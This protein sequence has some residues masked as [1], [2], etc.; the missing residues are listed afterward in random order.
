MDPMHSGMRYTPKATDHDWDTSVQFLPVSD[1]KKLEKKKGPGKVGAA[2]GLVVFF[3]VI[4]LMTGLLVWHF[5]FRKDVRVKKMYTG[6]MRITNQAFQEAY[7]DP[8]STEFKTL[9]NQIAGQLKEIYS[10]T[11]QLSKYYV[12]SR[13]Q[14]FSE[15]SVIAYYTSEFN[16]PSGQEGAVDRTMIS[17][18]QIVD[19][20]QQRRR[21]SD[22]PASD[23]VFDD[24]MTSELDMRLFRSPKAHSYYQHTR[25]N[26]IGIVESPGFPNY[27]YP[28]NNLVQWQLRADKGNVIKLDFDTF[29]LEENCKND[30]VKIYDSLVAIESRVMEEICGYFSQ[31]DH[32][33]FISSGN[34]MLVS[35]FTNE[36]R[37]YPGFRAHVSQVPRSTAM[38]C[39]GTL[40][41]NSG[42]FTSPHYPDYYPPLTT[43]VW[44][45]QVPTGKHIK[46]TFV[47]FLVSE[48]GQES[49][50][51][52]S[53]DHVKI[54][55]KKLCGDFTNRVETADTNV[56]T[57]VFSSDASY[58][59]RGFIATYEAFESKD[60]CPKKFMCTNS[61][62]IS[63]EL[64]C[65]GWND[66]GDNSDEKNCKCKSTQ[67]SCKNGMC[68]PK[69][70][71]C[72]GVNDCGD[73]TDE[74]NCGVC[75]NGQFTCSNAKCVS[76]KNKCDGRDDCGDGSDEANCARFNEVSC[77]PFSFKCK[78]KKCVSKQNPE[79]D[80]TADCS[81]GSDEEN[82]NCGKQPFKT[83]RIVGGQDASQGEFPWQVSLHIKRSSHVCG[84][85]II[86]E[87]WLVTAA[88][89][90]QDDAKTRYSHPST[91]DV[92]LGLHEQKDKSK[93]VKRG[94]KQV[95]SHPSYNAYT[96][97]F[98]I[99]LMELDSPV[100]L[101]DTVHPICLPSASHVF[102]AGKSVWIT[103]WGA[104]REGAS[105]GPN[106]LQKAEVRIINSTVCNGL[107][108]GQLTSRMLCAGVLSGGV[109]ACQ[110]DSGG[111]LS[112]LS[113]PGGRMF[114]AGVVSWGDGCARRNKPG[115]YTTVTKLR[116]WIKEKTGV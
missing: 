109:D 7:E 39:G 23:L 91:W 97:D 104:T 36:A 12:G 82:C 40:L 69:F 87:R 67:I 24:I 64:K 80:G 55:G 100:T 103:G 15:G 44:S 3:L 90:V 17:M 57:V 46:V 49:S 94:L 108:G 112:S 27:P 75:S 16:V 101:S 84:A 26:H 88:H 58:V 113:L 63:E 106:V 21:H 30:F 53:K 89:C 10:K 52:C 95:I 98:D 65:D 29:N 105:S 6:S 114:L 79:C 81:D 73:N 18:D 11:P 66:C 4:S 8:N 59:D 1:S 78:D 47:K 43:C 9:A 38:Q 45:I 96:F 48:P 111:P 54:N 107:M 5:H 86:N 77:T 37:N 42:T 14:A 56:L 51:T 25:S 2:I 35:F 85:A 62:C 74:K 22:K 99:A 92:Y 31:S 102:P 115:I 41:G 110:G 34:V 13:I 72:D 76:E 20:Q 33:A 19:K 71:L 116:G 93:A 32:L 83:S 50:S 61:N 70:W 68:K 60:P 28:P